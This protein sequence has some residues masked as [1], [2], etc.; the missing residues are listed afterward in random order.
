LVNKLVYFVLADSII[1]IGRLRIAFHFLDN[2]GSW[3]S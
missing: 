1:A 2:V 3:S